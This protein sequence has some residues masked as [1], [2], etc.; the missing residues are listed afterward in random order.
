MRVRSLFFLILIIT[1]SFSVGET[2]FD[3]TLLNTDIP[4]SAVV[5]AMILFMSAMLGIAWMASDTFALP[6]LKAWVKLEI[7]ELIVGVI[8]IVIV[9]AA[10]FGIDSTWPAIFTGEDDPYESAMNY[11]SSYKGDIIHLY[12]ESAEVA[13]QLERIYKRQEEVREQLKTGELTPEKAAALLI[14]LNVEAK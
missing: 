4:F 1:L 12:K 13:E 7:R 9:Y 3:L 10:L 2:I 8:L 6:Q 5:P 14:E 11:V